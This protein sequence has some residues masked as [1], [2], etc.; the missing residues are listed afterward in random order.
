MGFL[1]NDPNELWKLK[2]IILSKINIVDL[3][4]DYGITLEENQ[5][6]QFSHK[7]FCI[8]HKGKDGGKERT[9]SLFISNTTN[10]FCCF[11]SDKSNA[12]HGTI[13]SRLHLFGPTP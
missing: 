5:T 8:F 4:K 1:E 13:W 6:G 9:A 2:D 12:A 7:T 3:I 11:G 10:S